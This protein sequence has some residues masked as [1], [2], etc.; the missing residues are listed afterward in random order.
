MKALRWHALKDIRVDDVAEAQ[1]APGSVKLKVH[2]CG[3]CGTD[4]HEYMDGPV[5]VPD[6]VPHPLTGEKA[7]ITLGHEFSGEIV[8]LGEGVEGWQV[9]DRVV[10]EPLIFDPASR[11]GRVG[12]YNLGD[13]VGIYGLSGIGGGFSEYASVPVHMLHR[14]P[15]NVSYEQ[16][17]LVEPAAVA[18]HAIRRSRFK[19]GDNVAVFGA[20]P[21]GLLIIEAL[22]VSGANQIFVVEL[23]PERSRR[24]AQLG[25][26]VL[27]P[28]DVNVI[29]HI[30][31]AT[32]GGVDVSFEVTGVA[33]VLQQSIECTR[34]HGETVVVSVWAEP[35][36][37]QPNALLLKERSLIGVFTYCNDYPA[38]LNLMA[39]GHFPVD[40]FVT[41]RIALSDVVEKGFDALINDKSQ[42][43]ILVSAHNA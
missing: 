36:P 30:I 6:K 28:K 34:M 2:W 24:A 21:I 14:L 37:I 32:D 31:E 5:F 12:L 11:E 3:I 29:E 13:D 15:D 8:A 16:G 17:A 25:G 39:R 19:P 9:G 4:L 20:G 26:T 27:N 35:A 7:P 10:V 22:R 18:L 43:K 1:A 33:P 42:V 38:V 41:D 40:A 23:S